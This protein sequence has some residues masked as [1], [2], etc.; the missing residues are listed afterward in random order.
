VTDLT[1][2]LD[3]SG[4]RPWPKPWGKSPDRYYVLAGLVLDSA[5]IA[6]AKAAI[7]T[8]IQAAFP[9]APPPEELH[10]GDLINHRKG[11]PYETM[12]ETDRLKL[13]NMVFEFILDLKPLLMGTVVD[14]SAHRSGQEARGNVAFSPQSYAMRGTVGRFDV[15]LQEVG[16]FGTVEMDSAGFQH[17]SA[18]RQMIAEIRARGTRLS[19]PARTEWIDSRLA[20]IRDVKFVLSHQCAGVQL[21]DFVAYATWSHFQRSHSRRFLQLE[22]LWRRR[23]GFIEPSVLPKN[24]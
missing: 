24:R 13:A 7:P 18:L 12:P 16:E 22:K 10:Y 14:K 5:Q 11:T 17:D 8:I 15:H 2:F 1:L 6:R 3:E 23:P 20:R 21:A 9:G 19:R 4:G